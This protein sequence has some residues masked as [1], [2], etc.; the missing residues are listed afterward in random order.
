MNTNN[1]NINTEFENSIIIDTSDLK[2]QADKNYN[3]TKDFLWIHSIEKDGWVLAHNAI[4]YELDSMH[5][6][7]SKLKNKNLEFWQIFCLQ[8]WWEGHSK[9]INEHHKN[10]DE[11]FNPFIKTRIIYPIK[12]ESDHLKLS[13]IMIQINHKI[14]ELSKDDNINEILDIWEI[15]QSFMI[16]HLR[17]EELIGLPLVRAYFTP[18][19]VF[20][21][22]NQFIK[23]GDPRSLGSF[24]HCLG[25]KKNTFE[26]MKNHQIPSFVWYIPRNG[27]KA[28]RSIYR[29]KMVSKLDSIIAGR[30]V[31][32]IHKKK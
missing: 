23:K 7:L 26:F 17:E 14:K 4:R 9:H 32:S 19:E 5:L 16:S 31:S 11:I 6:A 24:I 12:L 15:Y 30:I 27:F 13:E 20:E 25:S 2:Y 22:T 28:L 10:E 18:L 29:E 3:P 21:C 8:E 1:N